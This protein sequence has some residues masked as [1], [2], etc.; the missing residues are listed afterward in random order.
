MEVSMHAA[1]AKSKSSPR[2]GG[3][4]K[5]RP[6]DRKKAPPTDGSPRVDDPEGTTREPMIL[7]DESKKPGQS[8]LRE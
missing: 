1:R 7:D 6:N 8:T 4:K 3:T 5:P 2:T